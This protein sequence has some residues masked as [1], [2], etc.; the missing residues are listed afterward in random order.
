MITTCP[1]CGRC[2]EEKSKE[3]AYSPT[4]RCLPCWQEEHGVK[5]CGC[6]VD[7]SGAVTHYC[8]KHAKEKEESV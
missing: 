2:Y 3:E 5:P 8:R 7:L 4:R 1:K 6:R